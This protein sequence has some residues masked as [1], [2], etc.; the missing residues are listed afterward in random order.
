MT[1]EP[2]ETIEYDR[3]GDPPQA[4]PWGTPPGSLIPT[5]Y[6]VVQRIQTPTG[7][8]WADL[9]LTDQGDPQND[10]P[11][12]SPSRRHA[13]RLAARLRARDPEGVYGVWRCHADTNDWIGEPEVID[14]P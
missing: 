2:P 6:A 13:R 5:E 9:W 1:A 10:Y 7:P 3:G 8:A 11:L 4:A 14:A 12:R